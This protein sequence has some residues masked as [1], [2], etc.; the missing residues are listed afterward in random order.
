MK[1]SHSTQRLIL[2]INIALVAIVYIGRLFYLQVIEDKYKLSADEN[3]L[4]RIIDYPS[5]GLVYDR[6]GKLLVFNQTVYDLMITPR[7][8]KEMDTVEFCSIIKISIEDFRKK[9]QK[10]KNYSPY[11]S[12]I[13]EKQISAETYGTLQEKLFKYKGFSVQPRTIRKYPY[14]TAAHLLGY[15]GEVDENVTAKNNYY[16]M[17]DYIGISGIEQS[18][19]K[20]LR[21]RRGTRYMMV[22]NF[23]REKGRFKEGKYD[24]LAISGENLKLSLDAEL[25]EYAELLFQNKRGSAVAIDPSTGE[26]LAMVNSP[27]YNPN[28]MV[29]RER[30]RNYGRLLK[31]ED[32]PLFNRAMMAY[33]PPGSTFKIINSLIGLQEK[34]ITPETYFSC[35]GGYRVGN[36]FVHCHPHSSP[37]DLRT[38]VAVSCN[39][40]Y[41]QTFRGVIDNRKYNRTEDAFDIWRNY[42]LSFGIGKKIDVDMPHE[43]RGNVPTVDYYNRFFGKGRWKSSTIISLA[44]GQGELGITPLQ[45]ANAACIVANKGYYYVPHIVKEI[46]YKHYLPDHFKKKNYTLVDSKYFDAIQDGMEWVFER[47]TARGSRVDSLVMCGKTGTA[48]NPH[49]KNHSVFFCFAPRENPK[50]AVAV[51]VE[52][53]GQGAHFAA[54][55]ASLMVQKYLLK[56]IKRPDLEK[57]MLDAVIVP[58]AKDST[59]LDD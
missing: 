37:L 46:G 49:G 11:R 25:Q 47:G 45:M 39:T 33:Y 31:D 38:A 16:Q 32:K 43:L 54:P 55:I 24:T 53:A 12:S 28:L 29:G 30:S 26:I 23:N 56:A 13:F 18:Y 21:G 15:L 59:V 7:E 8:V 6:N 9:F 40:Y 42:V 19:E 34:V 57:R 22:D 36:I 10:A 50:I 17:G 41:C 20:E 4:R 48:Q 51:L 58:V 52:N 35:A 27:T 44:I 5:R 1:T 2:V 3:V 14:N